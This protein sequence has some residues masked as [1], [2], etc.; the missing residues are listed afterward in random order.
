MQDTHQTKCKTS[1]KHNAKMQDKLET[2]SKH[3]VTL[4]C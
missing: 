4:Q 3:N 1:F 2:R